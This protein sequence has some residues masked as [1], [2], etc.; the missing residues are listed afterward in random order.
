LSSTLTCRT[1]TTQAFALLG[2]EDEAQ[3]LLRQLLDAHEA[4]WVSPY[5]TAMVHARLQQA[6][7][8]MHW[9]GQAAAVRDF[10]FVCVAIAPCLDTLH[11]HALWPAL[12]AR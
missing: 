2:R 3:A 6:D 9:L 8:A 7:E 12:V 11:G 5:Q 1:R 4:G 10:N